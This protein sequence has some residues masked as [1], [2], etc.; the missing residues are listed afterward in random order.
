[1]IGFWRK[2]SKTIIVHLVFWPII[3]VFVIWGFERAGNPVGSAAAVVNDKT[4]TISEY[5]NAL[6][7]VT[8][9]YSQ[10][11][12]GKFDEQAVK[13]YRV[14][15]TALN[16]LITNELIYEQAEKMGAYTTDEEVRQKLLESPMLVKDGKF[17]RDNYEN[18]LRY[19]R[20]T[21][22]QFEGDLRKSSTVDK[23]RK[24]FEDNLAPSLASVEKEKIL[25]DTKINL[26]FL[27]I[28]KDLL[29]SK[30]TVSEA[31]VAD[32]LKSPD[33]AKQVK[34]FYDLHKNSYSTDEQISA[35]HILIKATRGNKAEEAAAREKIAK[36][37]SELKTQSFES[38][39]AKYSDD[40]G[41][42]IKQGDLGSFSKGRMVPEF[43][44][45][46]FNLPVG[47]ISDPVQSDFGFHLIRVDSKK[48]AS[49]TTFE[50]AK[51][52]IARK[53]IAQKKV[54]DVIEAAEKKMSSNP[55]EGVKELESLSPQ[56]KWEDTGAF[57]IGD[58]KV[59]KIGENEEA[60]SVGLGLS[61]AKPYANH[62]L[63]SGSNIYVLKFKPTA[64]SA[65][66]NKNAPKE[67][68]ESDEKI[69]TRLTQEQGREIFYSWSNTLVDKAKITRN[70]RLFS[71]DAPSE[72]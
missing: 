29:Q 65:V 57:A 56:S 61:E 39:A 69:V 62:F 27:K 15:E 21:P 45:A 46:A 70:P 52:E 30:G 6:Q 66:V 67:I 43:E 19:Y 3:A 7:R 2:R 36:I 1:M 25:K 44:K 26:E 11:F 48:P 64:N 16:Q 49:S 42:K 54:D 41:S 50:E 22:A 63:R 4:I 53:L 34:E 13:M 72:E 40:P 35:H 59:P 55:A 47:K 38:L 10:M 8:D 32:Y 20:M 14:R 68:T 5:R 60:V 71:D 58:E 33:H 9:F 28:D 18:L 23:V 37:Q 31:E 24:L 17:N 12:Q 51:N